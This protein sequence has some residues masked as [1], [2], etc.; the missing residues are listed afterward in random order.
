MAHSISPLEVTLR[1]PNY[2]LKLPKSP[3]FRRAG[4]VAWPKMFVNLRSTRRTELQ[5]IF[6]DHVVN[7]WL[8]HSGAVAAKHYLQ[9]T[10]EHWGRAIEPVLPPVI[11]GLAETRGKLDSG[12]LTVIDEGQET[13]EKLDSRP[14][15]RSLIT[16]HQG[17]SL[18][19]TDVKKP[20]ENPRFDGVVH[21]SDVYEMTP[22]GFEPVL[23]P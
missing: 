12:S 4:V 10:D 2:L 20:R 21:L 16:D 6:P 11:E 7:S 15:T 14:L 8:G 18:K 3:P 22:T 13:R 19:G 1:I 17:P 9:V 5:E 23:P